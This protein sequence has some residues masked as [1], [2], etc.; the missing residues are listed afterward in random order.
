MN[1]SGSAEHVT[2]GESYG[3]LLVLSSVVLLVLVVAAWMLVR[4]RQGRGFADATGTI[5]VRARLALDPKRHL[6]VI[7]VA[8]K[9]LL[10]GAGEGAVS[11]VSDLTGEEIP[12]T[13]TP[14]TFADVMKSVWQKKQVAATE[15][16]SDG[17]AAKA[18]PQ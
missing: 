2:Y 14:A 3:T 15:V 9:T 13:R 7:D 8:G 18:D 4:W 5:K 6:Y 17:T 11:L 10:V 16:R 1:G 12:E